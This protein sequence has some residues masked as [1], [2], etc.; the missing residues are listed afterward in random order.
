MVIEHI[1][2]KAK[3]PVK[4]E[5]IGN[6]IMEK[7]VWEAKDDQLSGKEIKKWKTI[8]VRCFHCGEQ[9]EYALTMNPK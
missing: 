4:G 7:E 6:G 1:C 2:P 8:I 5:I 9:H 3:E